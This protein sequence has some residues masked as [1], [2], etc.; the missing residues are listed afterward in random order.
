[1]QLTYGENQQVNF[2]S[3]EEYYEVLGF[4]ANSGS[5]SLHWE[6]NDEQGAWGKE[7]RI[8]FYDELTIFPN[9]FKMTR[10]T[11]N[12]VSRV[13]C[14]EYVDKLFQIHNFRSGRVIQYITEIRATVNPAYIDNFNRGLNM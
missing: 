9:V 5:I 11:G 7:G 3:I 2:N 6:D 12:I 13:N 1:M 14:N 10:G 8:H 4:F